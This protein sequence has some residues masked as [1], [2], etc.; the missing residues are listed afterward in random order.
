MKERT[1]T[2]G[3]HLALPPVA[4]SRN[5]RADLPK[6]EWRGFSSSA[7][8]AVSRGPPT[9]IASPNWVQMSGVW[10]LPEGCVRDGLDPSPPSQVQSKC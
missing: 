5:Q 8:R 1:N 6:D 3:S 10:A 2:G 7:H 9:G 4:V